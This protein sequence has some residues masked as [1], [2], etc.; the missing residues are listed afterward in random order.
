MEQCLRGVMP[1]QGYMGGDANM[2]GERIA[3]EFIFAFAGWK[4]DRKARM[5]VHRQKR[6][7]RCGLM[8]DKCAATTPF[9]SMNPAFTYADLSLNA[10]WRET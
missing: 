1:E 10:P 2:P 6:F 5:Q 4:G 7:A 8:C 3:G 9:K